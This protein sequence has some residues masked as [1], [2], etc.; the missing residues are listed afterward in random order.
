MKTREA[1]RDLSDGCAELGSVLRSEFHVQQRLFLGLR[2]RIR[3]VQELGMDAQKCEMVRDAS[4]IVSTMLDATYTFRTIVSAMNVFLHVKDEKTRDC[5]LKEMEGVYVYVREAMRLAR[6]IETKLDGMPVCTMFVLALA[7]LLGLVGTWTDV[8][9]LEDFAQAPLTASLKRCDD[10]GV[11]FLSAGV[12]TVFAMLE[13]RVY[14]GA[15]SMGEICESDVR[16]WFIDSSFG[17]QCQ[18]D[19]GIAHG[20]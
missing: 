16:D 14:D 8:F 12:R 9:N 13:M 5:V 2:Q 11:G 4:R 1:V 7:E 19:V 6:E 10:V 18:G 20:L 15:N 3:E 17:K